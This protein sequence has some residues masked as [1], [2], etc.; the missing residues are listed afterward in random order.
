MASRWFRERKDF[1]YREA[2]REGYRARSAFKLLQIQDKYAII[3]HGDTVL[4]LGAAPGGWSQVAKKLIGENGR[5]IGIDILDVKPIDGI[6]FL[7]GDI[8]EESTK[9]KVRRILDGKKVDVVLS[10]MSPN[11]SGNYSVDQARSVWLSENALIWAK[12][13]LKNGGNFICKVFEG[14]DFLQFKNT[15]DNLFK[16][17]RVFAPGASRKS[18]SEVYLVAKLLKY[19]EIF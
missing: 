4:D 16:Q 6:Y 18:S 15:V 13:F 2:K 8:T 10:D 1:Y 7:H 12:E 3:H 11:I 17:V 19:R 5:V 14:R 9:K